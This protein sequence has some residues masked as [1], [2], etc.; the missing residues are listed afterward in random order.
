M[1]Y[2]EH[3]KAL[4]RA[5]HERNKKR[6]N[7]ARRAKHAADPEV[8]NGRSRTWNAE[9]KDK[10][11]TY[12]QRIKL[13]RYGLQS[14]AEWD[15]VF[16]SQGHCCK[17]CGAKQPGSKSG[18]HTDHDHVTNQ[19]RGILCARCNQLLGQLGDTADGVLKHCWMLLRYLTKGAEAVYIDRTTR[20]IAKSPKSGD[21]LIPWD[22]RKLE[23]YT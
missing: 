17:C 5:W 15:A 7:I 4:K 21:I 20:K 19:L 22:D 23:Y 8:K 11:S 18:W 14:Q 13:K 3:K 9:N 12:N 2:T 1:A 10:I 6:V 16:A